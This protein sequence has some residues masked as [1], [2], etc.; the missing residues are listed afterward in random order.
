MKPS[1]KNVLI[2]A[3][4][5]ALY[6]SGALSF[7]ENRLID[8]RYRLV[9]RDATQQVVVVKIDSRSLQE[10]RVWPWPRSRYA[11]LLDRLFAAGATDVA[12]DIDFSSE[13]TP[14]EDARFADALIRYAPHVILPIFKQQ[15][16]QAGDNDFNYTEPIP[17]FRQHA[18][19]ASLNVLPD[20]DGVIRRMQIADIWPNGFVPRLSALLAG[21][22]HELTDSFYI[23]YGIRVETIPQLSFVDV[24]EGRFDPAL[25]RGKRILIGASAVELGDSASVPVWSALPGSFVQAL[26]TESLAQGRALTRSSAPLV[27]LGAMLIIFL[28][29]ARLRVWSWRTGLGFTLLLIVVIEAAAL[30][31]QMQFPILLDTVPWVL[32]AILT[33]GL[34]LTGR[35]EDQSVRLLAQGLALRQQDTLMRRVVNNTFDGLL[36]IDGLGTIRSFNPAAQRIFGHP[37]E[38]II[39]EN[40]AALLTSTAGFGEGAGA[41]VSLLGAV[42]KS[43]SS[44]GIMGRRHDE[45]AFPM[46]LAVTEMQEGGTPVY[47]ALVRDISA[48]AAAESMAAEAQQRLVDAI[49][50]IPEAFVLYDQ[51]DRVLLFNERFRE[52]HGSAANLIAVGSRFE[53]M[54]R[55]VAAQGLAPEAAGRIQEWVRERVAR[56]AAPRGSFEME[57]ADGRWVRINERRTRDGGVVGILMDISEEKRRERELSRARDMAELANRS[58]SEFLANMSHELRT[59][60]NAIIGFS[61]LMKNEVM[62]SI[63]VPAYTGYVRDIHDSAHHLLNVI[64]DILDLSRIEAGKLKLLETGVSLAA[65]AQATA[66]LVG[67]RAAEAG[68]RVSLD[69]EDGLPMLRGDE[70]LVKQILNNLLTNAVKF[71]PRGGKVTIRVHQESDNG[72]A[73]AVADTGIGI[74]E[75]DLARVM[76]PF[77]QVDGALNRRYEGAGLGLTLVRSFV[78]LH[79]ASFRLV[80]QI[81]TG[82]TAS[83][84]FPPERTIP[85]AVPSEAI[86]NAGAQVTTLRSVS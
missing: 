58:K 24:L 77:G 79:G 8:A 56:H 53:D 14:V 16:R 86:A 39:G 21:S 3:V 62:G 64:N 76:E 51:Q 30:G 61:E 15:D 60:L 52:L 47:I 25:V 1:L 13:S 38:E 57:L 22:D 71:T 12:F 28:G 19:L 65:A 10:F 4:V 59:P 67:E 69:V 49:E 80:S 73:F 36:T 82:T 75:A 70:R 33:F 11:D 9:Q 40:F 2:L 83:V 32:S 18:R 50:S 29:G 42:A 20:R 68:V 26:A 74:A 5:G 48:R 7:I 37:P 45:S 31:L 84:R 72:L 85:R 35:I 63:G 81:G 54:T 34:G 66:R 41:A 46:D 27:L 78:D 17:A 6:L 43:G 23:D 44:R 55:A